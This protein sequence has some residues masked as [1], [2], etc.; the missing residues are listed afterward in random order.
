MAKNSTIGVVDD[1]AVFHW[2]VEEYLR[3]MEIDNE[4]VSFY[5]G[6]EVYQH[7]SENLEPLP[8]VLL[9][10][11]NMPICDGWKFLEMYERFNAD[12]KQKLKIYI[13][14]SSIDPRD[15]ARAQTFSSVQ[16]FISKPVTDKILLS[17]LNDK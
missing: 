11:I 5:N 16:N 14:T 6:E 10:D 9:L 12:G 8:D 2:I 17:I 4:V 1:E 13:M 3:K 7:L 15:K